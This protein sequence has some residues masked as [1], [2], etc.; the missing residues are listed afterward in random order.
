M[1]LIGLPCPACGLTRAGLLFFGGRFAESFRM[2]PLF[3]PTF[4]LMLVVGMYALFWP[5]KLKHMKIPVIL[6]IIISVVIY[7]YRMVYMFPEHPPM[8]VNENSILHS[9]IYLLM[10][11]W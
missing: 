4:V 6:F 7:I 11:M 10:M 9:I 2:H 8:L 1:I 5:G 3:V